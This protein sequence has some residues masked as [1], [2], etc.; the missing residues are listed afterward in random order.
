MAGGG[1]GEDGDFG[2]QI[3]PMVDVVFVLLLFFMAFAGQNVKEGLLEIALPSGQTA[4]S[5]G[6]PRVP[7]VVD[8]DTLGNVFINSEAA[9]DSKAL[10]ELPRLTE[11][12]KR[13]MEVEAEDPVVIRPAPDTRH[14][15]VIDVLNSC[16]EANVKKLSFG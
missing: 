5:D 16:R 11:K 3:A 4:G 2:F 7:I 1:G 13:S 14:E 10:R 15:R 8:I 12:L 6:T 9:D